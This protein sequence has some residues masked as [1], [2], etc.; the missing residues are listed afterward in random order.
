[1][2]VYRS[3]FILSL[4][5]ISHVSQGQVVATVL[6]IQQQQG[7]QQRNFYL[8]LSQDRV[9][10]LNEQQQLQELYDRSTKTLYVLD[11]QQKN[12]RSFSL[13]KAQVY[14]DA[15]QAMFR[16]FEK[17]LEQLPK[18]QR[19]KQLNRLNQFFNG[20]KAERLIESNY[21]ATKQKGQFAGVSCDWYEITEQQALKGHT[22]VAN[23]SSIKNGVALLEM[24]QSMD[25]IYNL[26]IGSVQGK[27]HLNIP[28]S[29]MA[30]LAKLGKIPL[31]IERQTSG[32]AMQ[33]VAVQERNVENMIFDLP[34]NFTELKDE[35][36]ASA[37][38]SD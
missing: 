23:P 5:L 10:N 26:I 27:L 33:L 30:P 29:P 9:A 1:M 17:K 31:S 20:G 24:L 28:N 37:V 12:Y 2:P 32:L 25:E 36:G 4:L 11:H 19:Q 16:K 3:L 13:P 7:A 34:E 38:T 18:Q 14:A 22:C 21:S 6:E 15:L 8:Y 35:Q